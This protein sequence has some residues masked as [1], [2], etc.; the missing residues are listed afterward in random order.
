MERTGRMTVPG[1][2]TCSGPHVPLISF[3][4]LAYNQENY[5]EQALASGLEQSYPN[6]EVVVSDDASTDGTWGRITCAAAGYSGP[7]KVKLNRN[8]VNLGIGGQVRKIASLVSG[9][10]IVLAGGDDVSK[11]ER[12]EV[13]AKAFSEHVN[14]MAVFSDVE[15]IVEHE[16]LVPGKK[17]LRDEGP[18]Q[19]E[20]LIAGGGGVGTGAAYAYR[21]QCFFWPDEFP[22]RL[23]SEDRI[24]PLRAGLLGEVRYV[25]RPLVA[26]RR[27]VQSVGRSLQKTRKL[28]KFRLDH[29]EV[30]GAH[31]DH[32]HQDG[33]LEKSRYELLNNQLQQMACRARRLKRHQKLVRIPGVGN[34]FARAYY[35]FFIHVKRTM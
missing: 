10:I 2:K 9:E 35:R 7:H 15:E 32:A 16:G 14:A 28:A 3:A 27:T 24:L 30:L 25:S 26:Y 4:I 13:L 5:I 20:S 12:V 19:L 22:D 18:V 23:I 31:L 8:E 21:R 17:N 29:L 34:I 33:L 11:P 6:L 1:E